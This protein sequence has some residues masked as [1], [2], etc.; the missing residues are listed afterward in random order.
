MTMLIKL[1][2][3][4]KENFIIMDYITKSIYR[5]LSSWMIKRKILLVRLMTTI[6]MLEMRSR[7]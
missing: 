1:S 2:N 3:N 7:I 4:Y 6:S 5:C